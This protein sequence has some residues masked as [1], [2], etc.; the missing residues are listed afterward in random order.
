MSAHRSFVVALTL[1]GLDN[2]SISLT[3]PESV[4]VMPEF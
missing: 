4:D 3:L 2:F 1:G